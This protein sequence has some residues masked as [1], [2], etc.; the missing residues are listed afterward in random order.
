MSMALNENFD[1]IRPALGVS[2]FS[3]IIDEKSYYC[4]KT[5]L[6][7][8]LLDSKTQVMLFTRPRRFGKTLNMTMLRTFF[9][10]SSYGKDTSH[11]FKNL[12]IWQAGEKYRAEQGKRPVIYL[13]FKDIKSRNFSGVISGIC[14]LLLDEISRH[15]YILTSPKLN[16]IDKGRIKA[17]LNNNNSDLLS[18]SIKVLSA[19]LYKHHGV[20]PL[21]LIDEYDVP[22]QAGYEFGF[23]REIVNFM[24]NMLSGAFKDNPNLYRGV[25]TGVSR[26]SKESIFSGLNNLDVDS[27]FSENFSTYFGF[28]QEEVD[29]MFKF[30]GIEDKL[31]EAEDWYDGYIFGKEHIY[32]PWSLL[33][34]V[35]NGCKP[36]DYW[37]NMSENS[38]VGAAISKLDEEDL[39]SLSG[40]M[41]GKKAN[42]SMSEHIIYPE[43]GETLEQAYCLLA[44]TG[45]LKASNVKMDI[46]YICDVEIPN[47]ELYTVYAREI[48]RRII[49]PKG[50]TPAKNISRMIANGDANGLQKYLSSFLLETCSSFDLTEEKDYQNLIIGLL[51]TMRRGYSITGNRE[52]GHGRADIIIK[53][54]LD[55]EEGK[56][57]PGIVIELKHYAASEA[58][59]D[60]PEAIKASLGKKA[61]EALNQIEQKS[62][63]SAL[64]ADGVKT[65]IKYGAAFTGKYSAVKTAW[66]GA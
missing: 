43:L 63:I 59:K 19:M 2:E 47:R 48:I 38:M 13:T 11:Y 24:R 39:D 64:Q 56:N 4:D 45:Y 28:T 25:L 60:N 46:D 17:I 12:K 54:R 35:K 58:E 41:S 49:K 29:D 1:K 27:I 65:I 34:Y 57:M 36:L 20:K 61:E 26:V 10:K 5:L 66:H 31:K 15:D 62:Y 7:K 14:G 50:R 30:Y 42:V 21:I 3:A 40:I 33:S 32:N 8:D 9:E 18:D 53:P 16:D 55:N 22:I 44:Q 23:Y 6:I 51:A 37:A 52:A